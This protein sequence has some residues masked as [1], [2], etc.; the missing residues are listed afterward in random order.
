MASSEKKSMAFN[1]VPAGHPTVASPAIMCLS[2]V[3]GGLKEY[4]GYLS[5]SLL[6]SH[7]HSDGEEG[8]KEIWA[9]ALE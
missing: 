5:L 2:S 9:Q 6:S 1:P 4:P 7:P 8:W 3:N